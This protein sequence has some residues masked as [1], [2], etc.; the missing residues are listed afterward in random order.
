MNHHQAEYSID[1]GRKFYPVD[2][3]GVIKNLA[4]Y[5][6]IVVRIKGPA[7]RAAPTEPAVDRDAV[8]FSALNAL[9]SSLAKN[10]DEGMIEHGR[11]WSMPARL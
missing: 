5:H 1:D 7:R 2:N 3:D 6:R 8:L 11:K 4:G 10:D 9:V